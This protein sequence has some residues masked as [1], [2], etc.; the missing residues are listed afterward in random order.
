VRNKAH[1]TTPLSAPP[2]S[3]LLPFVP[4]TSNP[5]FPSLVPTETSPLIP[6]FQL[7]DID[8]QQLIDSLVKLSKREAKPGDG[9]DA[10]VAEICLEYIGRRWRNGGD[11]EGEELIEDIAKHLTEVEFEV[12]F[13]RLLPC[14][15]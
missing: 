14:V 1:L 13:T 4:T 5:Y 3:T 15:S 8:K 11:G 7:N 12:K 9:S 10:L 2:L 6:A